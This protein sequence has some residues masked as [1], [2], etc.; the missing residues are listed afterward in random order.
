MPT[1][2]PTPGQPEELFICTRDCNINN[3]GCFDSDEA[4][5]IISCIGQP[6]TESCRRWDVNKDGRVTS[7]DLSLC[8]SCAC[9]PTST[10]T[11]SPTQTPIKTVIPK[12]L[13]L[14]L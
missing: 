10:P 7:Q 13:P 9:Q 8:I 4:N 12:N 3:N 1:P 5:A 6:M 11:P 2:T 14:K